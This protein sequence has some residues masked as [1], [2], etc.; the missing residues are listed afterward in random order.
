MRTR[1]FL[2]LLF[3][4]VVPSLAEDIQTPAPISAKEAASKFTLP[5]GFHATLFAGEPDIVQPMS[6]TFDDRGRMWVV[7]CLSYP[8]WREDGIGND[9]ITILEDTDNDGKHDK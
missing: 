6:F 5:D 1:A 9:R 7:E 8:K 3:H 4:I 2:A